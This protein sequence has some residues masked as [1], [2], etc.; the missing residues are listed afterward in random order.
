MQA[1]IMQWLEA[2]MQMPKRRK[3]A[4]LF[5]SSNIIH[6]RKGGNRRSVVIFARLFLFV[7]LLLFF[8]LAIALLV[9]EI[10]LPELVGGVA[11]DVGEDNLE[12][13][14]VPFHWL[15]FDTFFDVLGHC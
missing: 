2:R 3:N 4:L 6:S 12:D 10:F 11:I 13:V 8:P 9:L 7:F 14:G 15:T 5:T 1:V